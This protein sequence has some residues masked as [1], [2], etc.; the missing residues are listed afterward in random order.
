[1]KFTLTA[2]LLIGITGF[3]PGCALPVAVAVGSYAADGG[4]LVATGKSSTDHLVSMNTQRDCGAF[5]A[6]VRGGPL[7]KD[8]PVGAPDPYNVDPNAP[9]RSNGESG[10]E[11]VRSA[12][13]GGELLTGD[14]AR[15]TLAKHKPP[16]LDAPPNPMTAAAS[17]PG[18]A[19]FGSAGQPAVAP[20]PEGAGV[21]AAG[22]RLK[23]RR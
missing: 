6:I 20:T 19:R 21:A 4:L 11:V 15:Q 13:D 1:M 12:G 3:L 22:S 14:E 23:P 17:V 10:T 7:C 16:V 18:E 8:R 2:A 5:R 9:F